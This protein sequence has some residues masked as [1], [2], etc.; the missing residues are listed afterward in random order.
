[1][2]EDKD[3]N[4]MERKERA[5]IQKELEALEKNYLDLSNQRKTEAQAK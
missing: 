5:R 2:V 3:K 1:M 4:H